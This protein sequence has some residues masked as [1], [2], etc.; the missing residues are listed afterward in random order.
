MSSRSSIK[1]LLTLNGR[2][3]AATGVSIE[4]LMNFILVPQ[5]KA[6]EK[7]R[8]NPWL[9][10]SWKHMIHVPGSWSTCDVMGEEGR[11]AVCCF[12]FR[13]MLV[14]KKQKQHWNDSGLFPLFVFFSVSWRKG[15]IFLFICFAIDHLK[16]IKMSCLNWED[17]PGAGGTQRG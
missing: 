6:V 7:S 14:V 16:I 12:K 15:A 8:C 4:T 13:V 1:L 11:W 2:W 10:H 5:P 9:A 3:L 17:L